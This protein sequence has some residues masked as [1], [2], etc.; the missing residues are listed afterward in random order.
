MTGCWSF[1]KAAIG[2]LDSG[3]RKAYKEETG[4]YDT[5]YIHEVAEYEKVAQNGGAW[6]VRALK[7]R[8]RA[9][10]PFLERQVH[11]M[12]AY[13][14]LTEKLHD[15]VKK[16]GIYNEKLDMFKVN[17]DI[18][19]ETKAIG[20]Q[21]VFPRGWLENEAV[22]LHMKYKYFLELL[23][24]GLY[25]EFFHYLRT[26]FVPFLDASVY[27]RSIL[28]NSSFI[29]SS[30]HPDE[31]LHGTGYVSRL[32]G[33]FAEMLT[34]WRIMTAGTSLFTMNGD[35]G[36]ELELKPKLSGWLFTDIDQRITIPGK[37]GG[38]EFTQSGDTFAYFLLGNTLVLYVNHG[39]FDTWDDGVKITKI[40]L[41]R[42][43][44]PQTDLQG[45]IHAPYAEKVR[46]GAYDRITAVI[47]K[48]V[49]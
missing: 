20:R 48:E 44:E 41:Y 35:G 42:A 4:V 8:S 45:V 49:W 29:V 16:S 15:A 30:A 28:E 26:S 11:M 21:N 33:A 31:R 7:F 37:E 13:P 36:L 17:A 39:H 9:I 5:Y 38:M 12:R 2:R 32:T 47:E 40:S 25:Q 1:W 18:M 10:Q 22:F 34:M 24:N 27:G 6:N 14:K 43:G 46:M 19:S 3:L 23:R